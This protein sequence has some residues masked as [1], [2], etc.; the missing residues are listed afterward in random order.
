MHPFA[1]AFNHVLA[2]NAWA[3]ARLKPFAGKLF[4]LRLPPAVLTFSLD[5]SGFVHEA[6][7]APEATLVATPGGFLRYLTGK[8]RDPALINIEGSAEFGAALREILSQLTWEAEED[9]SHLFGDVLAHRIAGFAKRLFTW[10]EQSVQRFAI[11]TSEYFTE[12]QPLLAKPRHV[13]QFAQ[14]VSVLQAAVD[15]LD[16]RIQKLSAGN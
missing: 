15:N 14:A 2:Q 4:Q 10:H 16:K 9:L 1:A 7:G 8:P 3:Q 11:G 12:E 13:T 5:E 6:K